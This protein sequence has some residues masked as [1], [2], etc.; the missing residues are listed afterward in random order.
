M[1][2]PISRMTRVNKLLHQATAQLL[3]ARFGRE[4][5]A[6]TLTRVECDSNLRDAKVYYSVLGD[7]KKDAVTFFRKNAGE[8]G[9]LLADEVT[10]KRHPKLHF[11][12]DESLKNMASVDKIIREL[13]CDEV[14]PLPKLEI[15]PKNRK[16][17]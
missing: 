1:Q 17:A 10:L 16:N 11:V 12:Y 5:V 13:E 3:R 7:D 6:I 4:T 15:K 2:E 8:V 9:R 14:T